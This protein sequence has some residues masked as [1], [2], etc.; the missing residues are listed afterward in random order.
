MRAI[1]PRKLNGDI[2][3]N[4]LSLWKTIII[5]LERRCR[6]NWEELCLVVVV[7]MQKQLAR[8]TTT[9]SFAQ[10]NYS[11]CCILQPL[12]SAVASQLLNHPCT[13]RNLNPALRKKK[14]EKKK[15]QSGPT[16]TPPNLCSKKPLP[17]WPSGKT[18]GSRSQSPPPEQVLKPGTQSKYPIGRAQNHRLGPA[19]GR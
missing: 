15:M 3:K 16:P 18:P 4:K 12:F 8:L 10:P 5:I 1:Q 13:H 7:D 11:T 19:R 17:P 9:I 14:K 2:I 6:N